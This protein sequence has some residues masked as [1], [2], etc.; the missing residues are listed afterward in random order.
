MVLTT[1][2]AWRREIVAGVP[3]WAIVLT[4]AD[5]TQHA[6]VK[7]ER[8]MAVTSTLRAAPAL[9]GL[10][11]NAPRIDVFSRGRSGGSVEA[12]VT[13]E[14]AR[15]VEDT[16]GLV[17]RRLEI[18]LGAEGLPWASWLP[19]GAFVVRSKRLGTDG[20][21]TLEGV[22]AIEVAFASR[23]R[24][25]WRMAPPTTVLA[26]L[27]GALPA[28]V[29]DPAVPA[30][31]DA[32]SH[33]QITRAAGRPWGTAIGASYD[34][35]LQWTGAP[36]NTSQPAS[37]L[38]GDLVGML[39]WALSLRDGG[40]LG[41]R[42]P[43]TTADRVI[44]AAEW[45]RVSDVRK[46]EWVTGIQVKYLREPQE[47]VAEELQAD[48]L[49]NSEFDRPGERRVVWT[50]PNTRADQAFTPLPAWQRE[51]DASWANAAAMVGRGYF[52]SDP[53]GPGG[54][55]GT[56][57]LTETARQIVLMD[58]TA[59]GFCGFRWRSGGFK[60]GT[61]SAATCTS[62]VVTLTS[63]IMA[64]QR[65]IWVV[66]DVIA[67]AQGG[68]GPGT[69]YTIYHATVTGVSGSTVTASTTAPD[70]TI[71]TGVHDVWLDQHPDDRADT[72]EVYI[73]WD[74]EIMRVTGLRP[75]GYTYLGQAS[76]DG[77]LMQFG[78]L[79]V[80]RA[81]A[82]HVDRAQLG[83]T[84]RRH[85]SRS[86]VSDVTMPWD[87]AR[88][89]GARHARGVPEFDVEIHLRHA[90]IVEGDRVALVAP[91]I[92]SRWH[93]PFGGV[94]ASVLWEVVS[95]QPDTEA[96]C[97]RAT[98]AWASQSVGSYVPTPTASL[99][100]SPP[101]VDFVRAPEGSAYW[102]EGSSTRLEG[103]AEEI[104]G[105]GDLTVAVWVRLDEIESASVGRVFAARWGSGD[106]GWRWE[107]RSNRS[108]RFYC[109]TSAT[110]TGTYAATAA[111]AISLGR[112]ALVVAQFVEGGV[113]PRLFVDGVQVSSTVTGTWPSSRRSSAAPL[114]IGANAAGGDQLETAWL[115]SLAVAAKAWTSGTILG[116]ITA[117]G[118]AAAPP[119]RDASDRPVGWWPLASL[120]GQLGGDLLAVAGAGIEDV[121]FTPEAP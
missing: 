109:A 103:A 95:S 90:D 16:V 38:I 93:T 27:I 23:L 18:Y 31:D 29:C 32:R 19:R 35:G 6:A 59:A 96:G 84:A 21:W 50:D 20:T 113:P 85:S 9:V 83:T 22:D 73:Q 15:A 58:A 8:G 118:H 79:E 100:L 77:S 116:L 41:V 40:Q 92:M 30:I 107:V 108:L 56:D 64:L 46:D 88:R 45:K 114:T 67:Y 33:W 24:G 74:D 2:P 91:D 98:L 55:S 121:R 68:I 3:T 1:T 4:Q 86:L 44:P 106:H 14:W 120:E 110:D 51:R 11:G 65:P 105:T 60:W 72:H 115:S 82:V 53:G 17:G 36:A 80:P 28:E 119:L 47:S 10:R 117:S 99:E 63:V 102:P 43:S 61:F 37:S 70:H 49:R 54:V 94:D 81:L 104:E 112:W 42:T 78:G 76:G 66:G 39:G 5:G 26:D 111:G 75:R 69:P 7:A 101:W 34:P 25:T 57:W 71:T 13:A 97:V 52:V 89:S 48:R 87:M 12:Q 62:G